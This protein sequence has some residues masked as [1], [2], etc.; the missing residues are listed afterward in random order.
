MIVVSHNKICNSLC[1]YGFVN[2]EYIRYKLL[3]IVNIMAC[4]KEKENIFRSSKE[5]HRSLLI[6]WIN[7]HIIYTC[8]GGPS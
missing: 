7:L 3:T 2:I 8:D 4:N 5:V 6:C 1:C